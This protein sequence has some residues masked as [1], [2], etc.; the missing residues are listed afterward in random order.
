MR[1]NVAKIA[2]LTLPS[3]EVDC[4]AFDLIDIQG[5]VELADDRQLSSD[6][7]AQR[8]NSPLDLDCLGTLAEPSSV[9]QFNLDAS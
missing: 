6:L 9:L 7:I 1:L 3:R 8:S 4:K 5:Y 2:G